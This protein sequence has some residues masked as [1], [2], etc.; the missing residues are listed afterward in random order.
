MA[1]KT[2]KAEK[3]LQLDE[4]GL[5]PLG[6]QPDG[7]SEGYHGA[8]PAAT[9]YVVDRGGPDEKLFLRKDWDGAQ[10]HARR[11]DTGILHLAAASLCHET[12][13]DFLGA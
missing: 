5:Y 6:S 10:L 2:L 9:L 12:V 11:T 7:C 4:Y 3:N 8:F 1:G 13:L